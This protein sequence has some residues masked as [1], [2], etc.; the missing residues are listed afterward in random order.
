MK[1][2]RKIRKFIFVWSGSKKTIEKELEKDFMSRGWKIV[3][4]KEYGKFRYT[5]DEFK[6]INYVIVKAVYLGKRKVYEIDLPVLDFENI[7]IFN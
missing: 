6:K 2:Q 5:R 4:H 7:S 1:K 3:E